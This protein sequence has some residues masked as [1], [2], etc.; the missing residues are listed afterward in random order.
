LLPV[1]G[2]TRDLAK[3]LIAE[4]AIP[5]RC[6]EDA[7]HIAVAAAN[8]IDVIVTWN[9]KHINNPFMERKICQTIESAGFKAPVIC[10]P[11]EL[12]GEES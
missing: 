3:L 10:S 4:K 9:L 5:E 8:E 2:K 12:V 7:L 6:P 1:D 11:E